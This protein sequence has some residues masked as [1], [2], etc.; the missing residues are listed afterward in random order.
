MTVLII[1]DDDEIVDKIN[2]SYLTF[3]N[4]VL[5]FCCTNKKQNKWL[6]IKDVPITMYNNFLNTQTKKTVEISSCNTDKTKLTI[7][8]KCKTRG[9]VLVVYNCGIVLSFR[10][11]YGSESLSQVGLF[12]LDTIDAMKGRN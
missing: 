6:K 10:E 5:I 8:N 1:L 12:L 3:Y 2:D 4:E 9:I 11:L 7:Y